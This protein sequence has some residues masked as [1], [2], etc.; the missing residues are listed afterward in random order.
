MCCS[1][2]DITLKQLK[3]PVTKTF[4]NNE[5]NVQM[6]LCVNDMFSYN[7]LLHSTHHHRKRK[8]V[9]MIMEAIKN[10]INTTIH[11]QITTYNTL[12]KEFQS[13]WF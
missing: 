3:L 2:F 5:K 7:S 6:R 4:L 11:H 1:L 13:S 12:K 10:H 8:N 9:I